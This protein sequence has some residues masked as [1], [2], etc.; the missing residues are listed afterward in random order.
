MP[1]YSN[2]RFELSGGDGNAFYILGVC[3][4]AMRRAGLPQEERDK[5]HKEATSGDYKH[6]LCTCMAW[7]DVE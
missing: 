1:K 3:L 5:F 4:S 7:F 2:I 6:L